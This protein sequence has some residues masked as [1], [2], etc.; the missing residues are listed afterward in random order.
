MASLVREEI[1]DDPFSGSVYVFR[2][3]RADRMT[4]L[5]WDSTGV[6]LLAKRLEDV[7]FR[8]PRVQNEFIRLSAKARPTAIPH[9]KPYST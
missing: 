4:L 7:D 3:K 1:N 9:V 2:A 6:C 5:F 8:W